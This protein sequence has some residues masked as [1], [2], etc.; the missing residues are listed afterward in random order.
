MS[1]RTDGAK[2]ATGTSRPR[3]REVSA[4]LDRSQLW[5][6]GVI[7]YEIDG[8]VVAEFQSLESA[9]RRWNER[10]VITLVPRT[11]ESDFVRFTAE[12]VGCRSYVGRVGGEQSVIIGNCAEFGISHEIGHVV[13]LLHPFTRVDRDQFIMFEPGREVWDGA[14]A[15]GPFDFNSNLHYPGSNGYETIP[16]GMNIAGIV[17][18]GDVDGVARLYGQPPELTTITTNPPGLSIVVDGV[19]SRTPVSFD[20]HVGSTHVV[21]APLRPLEGY[22]FGR[23]TDGGSRRRIIKADRNRT[24]FQA[25][26]INNLRLQEIAI[27]PKGAGVVRIN[28]NLGQGRYHYFPK[29]QKLEVTAVPTEGTSYRFLGW[30]RAA[31][32]DWISSSP[33][34]VDTVTEDS[35]WGYSQTEGLAAE[36]STNPFFVVDS[37]VQGLPI[38]ALERAAYFLIKFGIGRN[39]REPANFFKR[40]PANFD[41]ARSSTIKI[42]A[43]DRYE[44]GREPGTRW[45][46]VSWSDGGEHVTV[47][48]GDSDWMERDLSVPAEGGELLLTYSTDHQLIVATSPD[49]SSG[50]VR[51]VPQSGEGYY[52]HGTTVQLVASPSSRFVRW[53]GDATGNSHRISVHMDR[54]KR[55]WAVFREVESSSPVDGLE[56]WPRAF[57]FL[58]EAD[59]VKGPSEILFA[60]DSPDDLR[61]E[62]EPTQFWTSVEPSEGTLSSGERRNVA[63]MVSPTGLDFGSH[64]AELTVGFSRVRDTNGPRRLDLIAINL[65]KLRSREGRVFLEAETDGSGEEGRI[66]ITPESEDGTYDKGSRVELVAIPEAG[67]EFQGWQGTDSN[68]KVEGRRIE[69]VLDRDR[70]CHKAPTATG[71]ADDARDIRIRAVFVPQ[72]SFVVGTGEE[73][74]GGDG[75]HAAQAQLLDPSAIALDAGDNLYIADRYRLRRVDASTK[76]ITTVAGQGWIGNVDGDGDDGPAVDAFHGFLPAITI[77]PIGNIYLSETTPTK[78]IRR[79]DAASG[80]ITTIAGRRIDAAS[81]IVTT[82]AGIDPNVHA[83][84]SD[85]VGNIYLADN[86]TDR[87]MRID[88]ATGVMTAVAG[89]G[90]TSF[91]RLP[92]PCDGRSATEVFFEFHAA[93]LAIDKD[94][95]IYV[96]NNSSSM[97][98]GSDTLCR[99]DANTGL[100]T[101]VAS[102]ASYGGAIALDKEAG[103]LYVS[104]TVQ[105][106]LRRFETS[107]GEED[108]AF[109]DFVGELN[110]R[111]PARDLAFDSLGNLYALEQ[112]EHRVVVIPS[113]SLR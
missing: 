78:R 48:S 74:F 19:R 3:R 71:C 94:G 47:Q 29:G 38:V 24:W 36:F 67:W 100:A 95:H 26:Y 87:V 57:A 102:L 10:T 7:P 4:I 25:S 89:G 39:R 20:W 1:E 56:V 30:R 63:V 54:P 50:S 72:G 17:S 55:V 49:S 53:A 42:V 68:D 64:Q 91:G 18:S 106:F 110:L 40:T 6:D 84:A 103:Y 37:N 83:L 113:T 104:S 60:N 5:P 77:D 14:P 79:I 21:E 2:A 16:P 96:S 112:L 34:I 73:G 44:D 51:Q 61:F 33:Q 111:W 80:I 58:A 65:V 105:P 82:I 69:I 46:F 43:N 98:G 13:G 76:V 62:F 15:T 81:G 85:T 28:P 31:I 35:H 109:S 99:I 8:T 12:E 88:A 11:S 45:Q 32:H 23:W 9:I 66:R 107:T 101:T 75:G 41:A 86:D 108:V 27:D 93:G 59:T 52:T 70:T 92:T 90:A 97:L 22:I